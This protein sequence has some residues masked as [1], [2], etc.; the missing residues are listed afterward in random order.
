LFTAI[1]T[2]ENTDHRISGFGVVPLGRTGAPRET[3]IVEDMDQECEGKASREIDNEQKRSSSPK[4]QIDEQNV[5]FQSKPSVNVPPMREGQKFDFM[6]SKE[7]PAKDIAPPFKTESMYEAR[8]ALPS[9][10]TKTVPVFDDIIMDENVNFAIRYSSRMQLVKNEWHEQKNSGNS[11][12]I[13]EKTII[14]PSSP[15]D[16]SRNNSRGVSITDIAET[17][18]LDINSNNT[19]LS[20]FNSFDTSTKT[21]NYADGIIVSPVSDMSLPVSPSYSTIT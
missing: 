4:E 16:T 18:M 17:K 8:P 11:P 7:T 15:N 2:I 10:N 14:L 19:M 1:S 5:P 6:Q 13:T 21:G 20:P 3:M 12:L 9:E